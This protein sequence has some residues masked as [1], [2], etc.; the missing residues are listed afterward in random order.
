MLNKIKYDDEGGNLTRLFDP[1]QMSFILYDE[2]LVKYKGKIPIKDGWKKW[3]RQDVKKYFDEYK[4]VTEEFSRKNACDI[5]KKIAGANIVEYIDGGFIKHENML[6]LRN[7][8]HIYT[9][10]ELPESI[11]REN[12]WEIFN[13][14]INF[15]KKE[16]L[17]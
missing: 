5:I 11:L 2:F 4:D 15:H 16:S 3:E 14:D 1:E 6:S 17:N 7:R 12:R 10:R 13:F 8:F 9:N